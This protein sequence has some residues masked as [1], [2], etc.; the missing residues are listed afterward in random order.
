MMVWLTR[1]GVSVSTALVL[2]GLGVILLSGWGDEAGAIE[3]GAPRP[4]TQPARAG[5]KFNPKDLD[6]LKFFIESVRGIVIATNTSERAY[7][8]TGELTPTER[9]WSDQ[10]RF[11][12]GTVRWWWD[13]SPYPR[14]ARRHN[15]PFPS[16]RAFGQDDHD[17][18]GYIPDGCNGKPCARGGLAPAATKGKFK[19]HHKQPCYFELQ[20]E[21]RFKFEGPFGVFLLVRPVKQ[22]RDFVYFGVFHWSNLFHRIRDNSLRFKNMKVVPLTG[23]DAVAIGKWQ[24]IEVHRDRDDNLQCVVN[25]RDVTQGTPGVGGPFRFVHI[26]NNNKN[27]W[28]GADPYAGDLAAFVLYSDQLTEAE[29]K[30]VRD[31]FNGIYGYMGKAKPARGAAVKR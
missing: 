3:A 21:A 17:R 4:T 20:P 1:N 14:N 18:P 22:K 5:K 24:L 8:N 6:N 26:M 12:Q 19:R 2:A 15:M 31:Y 16:G 29:K 27:I 7:N 10:K 28:R 25:G 9:V 30:K 13:Q 11:P 23:P